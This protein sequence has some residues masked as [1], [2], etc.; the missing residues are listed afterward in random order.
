MDLFNVK[1]D[2]KP[3]DPRLANR[4]KNKKFVTIPKLHEFLKERLEMSE[5]K[6]AELIEKIDHRNKE[7]IT[8]TEFLLFINKEAEKREVINDASIY[9]CG[10][11]RFLEGP[12]LRPFSN[13]QSINYGIDFL[14]K[15]KLSHNTIF[16]MIF[17]NYTV[18]LFNMT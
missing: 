1:L 5:T 4:Q 15:M 14:L 2:E 3:I 7:K 11:K 17:E 6:V 8:W 12:R 9:G 18:G 10:T 13:G 16:L